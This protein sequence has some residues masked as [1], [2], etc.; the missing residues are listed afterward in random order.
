MCA[1]KSVDVVET[2]LVARWGNTR[3]LTRVASV[4]FLLIGPL[5]ALAQPQP[6]AGPPAQVVTAFDTLFAG[7]HQG[8]RAVHAKGV[9]AEGIFTP[10]PGADH[11]SHAA[12]LSGAAVPVLVR[13]SNFAG[14]PGVADHSASASPRGVAVRFFLSDGSDTDIVGHSYD[15]FP[16]ATP[17]EFV[18]FL[19]ALVSPAALRDFT[20]AHPAARAFIEAP[21]PTPAS[22][23]T[24][25]YFGVTAF[26]FTN[27]AGEVRYGRY[28]LQPLAGEQHLSAADASV[29]GADFL[30][31][32]L[33]DRLKRGTVGF[34]LLVQL[35]GPGDDV[36]DGSV[37]WPQ[38]RKVVTLGTLELQQLAP[39]QT[40][41]QTL[42]FVPT[43]LISGIAPSGDPMLLARTL[44]YRISAD[45]R[46]EDR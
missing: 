20:A 34:V 35:A 41:Q 38:D 31:Q 26:R 7:P 44:S 6:T 32:D 11:V 10:A 22:Y 21:K 4:L 39:D 3:A 23:G 42:R 25:A 15:G 29:R 1:I 27:A 33:G 8:M 24:E 9:L 37:A 43:N 2:T 19:Q 16:A 17:E 28:R 18:G 45:R 46:S 12:H 40:A 30:T 14:V 13:F 5:T 36:T